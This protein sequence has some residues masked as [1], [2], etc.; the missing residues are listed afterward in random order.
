MIE[1]MPLDILD[2][3]PNEQRAAIALMRK[4]S[5]QGL[6]LPDATGLHLRAARRIRLCWSTDFHL[7]LTRIPLV[8]HI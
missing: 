4:Y 6:T 3:G 7:G 1:S 5:D 2:V 8:I